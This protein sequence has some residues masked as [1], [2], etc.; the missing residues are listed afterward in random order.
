MRREVQI[1]AE[2]STVLIKFWNEKSDMKIEH[3]KKVVITNVV[4][5]E[6]NQEKCLNTSDETDVEVIQLIFYCHCCEV[7]LYICPENV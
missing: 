1:E 3:G 2:G 4:T 6:F 5:D 7:N